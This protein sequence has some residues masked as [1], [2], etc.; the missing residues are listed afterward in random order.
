MIED[1]LQGDLFRKLNESS[2]RDP[3]DGEVQPVAGRM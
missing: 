1:G 3:N 2:F